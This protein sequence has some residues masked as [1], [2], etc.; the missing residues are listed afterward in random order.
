M[1]SNQKKEGRK[2]EITLVPI[3]KGSLMTESIVGCKPI[4]ELNKKL[5]IIK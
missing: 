2:V 5:K 3:F 4:Y 1:L